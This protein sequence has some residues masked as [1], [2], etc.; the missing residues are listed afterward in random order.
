MANL[1]DPG[2]KYTASAADVNSPVTENWE[3]QF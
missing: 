3:A 1:Y 2:R